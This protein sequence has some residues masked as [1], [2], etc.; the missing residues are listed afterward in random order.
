MSSDPFAR[1]PKR[2]VLRSSTLLLPS[3]DFF[4]LALGLAHAEL[5]DGSESLL[6]LSYV[7][8]VTPQLSLQ[9]DLQYVVQRG[10][11]IPNAWVVALRASVRF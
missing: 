10:T 11:D 1:V 2:T 5:R 6:E 3:L 8:P 7:A 9:P 4:Q